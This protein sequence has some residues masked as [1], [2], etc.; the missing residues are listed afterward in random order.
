MYI[1]IRLGA[2]T[3]LADACR[4]EVRDFTIESEYFELLHGT[5][6]FMGTGR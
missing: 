1:W 3:A 6:V 5:P 4:I 2:V